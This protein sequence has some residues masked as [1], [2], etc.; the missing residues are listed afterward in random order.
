MVIT[1]IWYSFSFNVQSLMI[2]L[3]EKE[4]IILWLALARVQERE[5]M[6]KG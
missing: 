4:V 6:L 3:K 5:S 2:G 1:G